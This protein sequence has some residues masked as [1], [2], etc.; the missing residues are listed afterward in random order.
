MQQVTDILIKELSNSDV[1]WIKSTANRQEM[2]PGTVVVEKG[3]P[4][5]A[6]QIILDGTL[7]LYLSPDQENKSSK[8][9]QDSEQ[10]LLKMT[11]G[12]LL[13]ESY[14]LDPRPSVFTIKAIENAQVLSI[15]IQK[16]QAKIR[17]DIGFATHL[18][19]AL[20]MLI[21]HRMRWLNSQLDKEK[22]AVKPPQSMKKVLFF[23]GALNDS[24]IDWLLTNGSKKKINAN[25]D[26]IKQGRPVDNLYILMEGTMSISICTAKITCLSRTFAVDDSMSKP[27]EVARISSGEIIG[28]MSFLDNEPASATVSAVEDSWVLSLPRCQLTAKLQVDPGFASRFYL[29]L[30][31]VLEDRLRS[32]LM[33]FS[34]PNVDLSMSQMLSE[35]IEDINEIDLDMLD[36]TAIA[37]ARFDWIM[38]RFRDM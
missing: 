31:S 26:L 28:E 27:P 29:A 32:N 6:F 4:V 35:E 20:A 9:N 3:K 16:I 33:R 2:N 5:E 15:P 17:Q 14:L 37:G 1:D 13:G 21:P 25:Q 24:D 8:F 12:E 11:S 22:L 36:D 7:G 10:E 38:R 34:K 23:L 19:R 18:Y 30:G